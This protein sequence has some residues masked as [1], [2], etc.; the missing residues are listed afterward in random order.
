[1]DETRYFFF[2]VSI[3]NKGPIQQTCYFYS[4]KRLF[5]RL[6]PGGLHNV[7]CFGYC[8]ECRL[9]SSCVVFLQKKT[10]H[11]YSLPTPCH[12]T[13]SSAGIHRTQAWYHGR[14]SRDETQRLIVQQ[15]MVD[16]VFLLRESTRNPK[17]FVLSLC[18]LQKIKH[19]L[20]L[21]CEEEGRPYFSMDD[22]QTKFMDLIQL[23]EFHQINRG[24]LPCNL[25][26]YCTCVAL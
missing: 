6:Y 20:I 8:V 15:G 16:G 12:T 9:M 10:S 17:G 1:M 13:L 14:L 24:I 5:V 2:S 25:K 11:R 22:G 26:H 7:Y 18:H 21:P 19:Y 4:F 23:V 3:S